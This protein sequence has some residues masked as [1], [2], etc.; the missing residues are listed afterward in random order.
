[1]D[2]DWN[3]IMFDDIGTK[4]QKAAKTI[5]WIDIV[6]S[7]IG[8][9][10]M[11]FAAIDDIEHLWFL[12]ILAP[13]VVAIGCVTAWLSVITLYG[14]GK[15]VEDVAAIRR[16]KEGGTISFELAEEVM[17]NAQEGTDDISY[18]ENENLVEEEADKDFVPDPLKTVVPN[19]YKEYY[20]CPKCGCTLKFGQKECICSW[21]MDWNK[22]YDV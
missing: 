14:F 22:Y 21:Q 11:L 12:I 16:Q 13:V 15:L 17:P 18:A 20:S 10:V 1:M 9:T 7:I 5:A 2:R 6:M 8:G 4:M 19:K 3:S